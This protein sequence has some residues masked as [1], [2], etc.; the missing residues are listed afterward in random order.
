MIAETQACRDDPF[1]GNKAHTYIALK[2]NCA[3]SDSTSD[4]SLECFDHSLGARWSGLGTIS[5]YEMLSNLGS[6]DLLLR[7]SA[8]ELSSF[9]EKS[10]LY[11]LS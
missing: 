8:F 2:K 11:V 6:C 5:S 3:Q 10:T 9:I 4:S 1:L 7:Y